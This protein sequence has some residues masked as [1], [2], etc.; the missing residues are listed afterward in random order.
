MFA[1]ASRCVVFVEFYSYNNYLYFFCMCA[2]GARWFNGNAV[3]E[4]L[5]Y[6]CLFINEKGLLSPHADTTKF[7]AKKFNSIF[8]YLFS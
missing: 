7:M 8:K 5:I 2:L 3:R 4:K 6:I 1:D